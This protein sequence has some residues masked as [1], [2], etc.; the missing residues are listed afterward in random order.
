MKK[1]LNYYLLALLLGSVSNL[2][3][4]CAQTGIITTVAGNGTAGHSG[5]HGAATAA[6]LRSPFGLVTD[7]IGNVYVSDMDDSTVRKI[8]TSGI[9]T[10][11]AGDGTS[12]Y[13][14]D[15]MPATAAQLAKPQGLA[16]DHAGNI[17]I[18]TSGVVRMVYPAGII[19]TVAGV[20]GGTGYS[21]DGYPATATAFDGSHILHVA[22]DN[23]NNVY[24]S[25]Q[26][27]NRVV[28][29]NPASGGIVSTVAGTGVAGAGSDGVP[30]TMSQLFWPAGILIDGANNLY[31]ADAFNNQ[32]RKIDASG[33]I[34]TVAGNGVLGGTGDEG[35]ATAAQ[36]FPY[37]ICLDSHGNLYFSGNGTVRRIDASGTIHKFAGAYLSFGY[38]GDNGPATDAQ[39]RAPANITWHNGD[40]FIADEGDSRV[41]KVH[42][43]DYYAPAF[44]S[45]ALT[46]TSV[47]T[48][49]GA[50]DVSSLL[51]VNDADT[52]EIEAWSLAAAPLHGAAVAAC[53]LVS[54]GSVLTPSGITYTPAAGYTG[55]DSFKVGICDAMRYDTISI[56]IVVSPHAFCHVS[57]S[58]LTEEM[59]TVFPNPSGSELKVA[60]LQ[61]TMNYKIYNVLGACV[62]QGSLQPGGNVALQSI[63]SGVYTLELSGEDRERKMLRI[64]KE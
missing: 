11:F 3:V 38:S 61:N 41:R 37:G 57:A 44:T 52:G 49:D 28:R 4:A 17:Y 8:D 54:T 24:I 26:G 25:S 53:S 19:S 20:P 5:D 16:I 40:L 36:I 7:A 64:E 63:P 29:F 31:I 21:G 43:L 60:G 50:V 18:A 47:C 58:N 56:Q 12:G 32:I 1:L 51:K 13:G 27:D 23:V 62:L 10:N 42:G 46:T 2:N 55:I 34:T 14:G 48:G 39:L 15:G 30:A 45:G 6:E 33:I 22:I 9:I 59:L 35:P